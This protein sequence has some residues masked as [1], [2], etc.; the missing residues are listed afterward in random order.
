MAVPEPRRRRPAKAPSRSGQPA[1]GQVPDEQPLQ[2]R[3]HPV[4]HR[5]GQVQEDR[6]RQVGRR[7]AHLPQQDVRRRAVGQPH[8]PRPA[9]GHLGGD[10][11]PGRPGAHDEHVAAGERR[12]VAVVGRVQHLPHEP[13]PACPLREHRAVEGAGGH[14]HVPGLQC[15]RTG[16]HPPLVRGRLQPVHAHPGA[17]R[18]PVT[19][20]ILLQV[21]H[22]L[23]PGGELTPRPGER[24][25]GQRGV[26]PAGVE[27]QR[28]VAARPGRR[29]PVAPLQ[30]R[31]RYTPSG[32]L[33]RAGE[34]GRA[35]ADDE[36]LS[37]ASLSCLVGGRGCRCCRGAH[38]P[39]SV[40]GAGTTVL[41]RCFTRVSPGSTAERCRGGSPG[42]PTVA[43]VSRRR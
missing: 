36:H 14:H 2:H 22:V 13:G 23:V 8:P 12:G 40:G 19:L 25:T 7:P 34:A 11:E 43:A 29:E 9:P 30:H 21:G 27:P 39:S 3:Q 18:H 33:R 42:H 15:P 35:A 37:V 5:G 26:P 24:R 41:P 38:G 20:G 6:H 28:V 32:Q 1:P 4:H 16:P 17:D 10:L 31:G